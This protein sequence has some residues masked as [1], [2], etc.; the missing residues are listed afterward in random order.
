MTITRRIAAVFALAAAPAVIFL[1]AA[2]AHADT[3]AA[4]HGPSVS[5]HDATAH[6]DNTPKPGTSEHHH[7]QRNHHAK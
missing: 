1:G 6:Q 7:H 3:S 5:H 2:S 4:N